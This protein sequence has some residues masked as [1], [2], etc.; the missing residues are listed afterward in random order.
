[1]FLARFIAGR[2][3]KLHSS[4]ASGLSSLR[5]VLPCGHGSFRTQFS[6]YR[7]RR[8]GD[9]VLRDDLQGWAHRPG[10]RRTSNVTDS[11]TWP[12]GL[13]P[14]CHCIFV[15]SALYLRWLSTERP[16][17]LCPS[18]DHEQSDRGLVTLLCSPELSSAVT[19]AARPKILKCLYLGGQPQRGH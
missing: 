8:S 18:G 2:K 11:R 6:L 5:Q 4:K 13:R 7:V 14:S 10:P 19:D 3:F 9:H 12:A 16:V 15:R 17:V 1:V